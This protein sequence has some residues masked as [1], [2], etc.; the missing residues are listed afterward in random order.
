[1]QWNKRL[2][3]LPDHNNL[4]FVEHRGG[5]YYICMFKKFKDV[6]FG[7]MNLFIPIEEMEMYHEP[8]YLD[9]SKDWYRDHH[10]LD[11]VYI[12]HWVL[13]SEID[14]YKRISEIGER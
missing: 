10:A 13:F 8:Y 6:H 7:D 2:D 3:R 12:D 5:N 4:V 11:E 9:E 14:P 1:M